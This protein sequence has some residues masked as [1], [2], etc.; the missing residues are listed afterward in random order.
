[1]EPWQCFQ[2]LDLF[3]SVYRHLLPDRLFAYVGLKVG[4][5]DVL[6]SPVPPEAKVLARQISLFHALFISWPQQYVVLMEILEQIG[7]EMMSAPG[8]HQ[9]VW[10]PEVVFGS[11]GS[12]QESQGTVFGAFQQIFENLVRHAQTSILAQQK[13]NLLIPARRSFLRCIQISLQ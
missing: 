2:L 5:P 12:G 4:L 1:M 13:S 9:R 3:C 8:N 10:Q 7:R 11:F 6:T